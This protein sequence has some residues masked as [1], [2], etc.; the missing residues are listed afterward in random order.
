MFP[1]QTEKRIVSFGL[2]RNRDD[3]IHPLVQELGWNF[4]T[5]Y[6]HRRWTPKKQLLRELA[7]SAGI[8]LY[9]PDTG[10][11]VSSSALPIALAS[12][13]PVIVSK[14]TW[15]QPEDL[16]WQDELIDTIKNLIYFADDNNLKK[17]ITDALSSSL[18]ERW[19]ILNYLKTR[20]GEKK[21]AERFYTFLTKL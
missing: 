9:Y 17:V 3:L 19:K 5:F 15:F 4:Q 8:T 20:I 7:K 2:G 1:T 11:I 14:T 6:G 18:S 21:V 16:A 10:A 13:R 12:G